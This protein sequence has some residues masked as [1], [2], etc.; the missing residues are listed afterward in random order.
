MLHAPPQ[1]VKSNSYSL[2]IFHVR[3]RLTFGEFAERAT[4][5]VGDRDCTEWNM[6][7]H[8]QN[9]LPAEGLHSRTNPHWRPQI[10][11]ANLERYLHLHNFVGNMSFLGNHTYQLLAGTDLW[12]RYGANG[13]GKNKHG[14]IFDRNTAI[15]R[16]NTKSKLSRFYTPE[17]LRKVREAYSMDYRLLELLGSSKTD[18]PVRAYA[19]EGL[20]IRDLDPRLEGTGEPPLRQPRG[21]RAPQMPAPPSPLL[22]VSHSLAPVSQDADLLA[23]GDAKAQSSTDGHGDQR[24]TEP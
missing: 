17:L 1:F 2:I 15:H 20:K 23:A 13:W 18:A 16:T 11:I 5:C 4:A 7:H 12:Q 22:S 19:W 14:Q 3:K 21:R 10:L 8:G 9:G 6:K 24:G